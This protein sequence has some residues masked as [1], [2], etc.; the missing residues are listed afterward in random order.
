MLFN[1]WLNLLTPALEMIMF[2][3]LTN[4]DIF[5]LFITQLRT[6]F[7]SLIDIKVQELLV[8]EEFK[9]CVTSFPG[10]CLN[11]LKSIYG[12]SFDFVKLK[13]ELSIIYNSRDFSKK[14]VQNI[15]QY[16]STDLKSAFE[17]MHELCALVLMLPSTTVSVECSFSSL[18]R[19][20]DDK[21]R[22]VKND[23]LT[24]L[25]LLAIGKILLNTL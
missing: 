12:R 7:A 3:F 17:E 13:S 5:Y 15:F 24:G 22:S 18:A 16:L 8:S 2:N 14:T 6:H 4:K 23:R 9:S 1:S 10:E 20:K 19:I 11:S 21:R 25:T